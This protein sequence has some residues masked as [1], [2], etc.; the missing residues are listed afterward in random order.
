M[1][2]LRDPQTTKLLR[3]LKEFHENPPGELPEGVLEA[4]ET[5]GKDIAQQGGASESAS[6]GELEALKYAPGTDGTGAPFQK[7]ARG[8]DGPSP[9]QKEFSRAQQAD[10]EARDNH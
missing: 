1:G 7:G 2:I 5:L 3:M 8:V 6:P 9:G 10:A 4:I